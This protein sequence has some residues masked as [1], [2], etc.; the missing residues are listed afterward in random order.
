VRWTDV[1]FKEELLHQYEVEKNEEAK[2]YLK[3]CIDIF[4]NLE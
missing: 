2:S 3:K 1:G 4:E